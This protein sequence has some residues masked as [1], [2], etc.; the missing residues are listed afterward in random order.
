M[1]IEKFL[2][3]HKKYHFKNPYD[4]IKGVWSNLELCIC[5]VS[6]ELE[7]KLQQY[8][9]ELVRDYFSKIIIENVM[10]ISEVSRKTKSRDYNNESIGVNEYAFVLNN[11]TDH[12]YEIKASLK[13]S[14]GRPDKWHMTM[15]KMNTRFFR[16]R[17][18]SDFHNPEHLVTKKYHEELELELDFDSIKS[19]VDKLPINL[20]VFTALTFTPTNIFDS[21]K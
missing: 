19:Y 13:K 6:L 7:P 20:Q 1:N 5:N 17:I 14:D 21:G 8:N 15:E 11:D 10:L 12:I 3:Q 16:F 9:E 18:D 4:E 2:D